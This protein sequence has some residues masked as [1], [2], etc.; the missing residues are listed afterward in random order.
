MWVNVWEKESVK[1]NCLNF[2][3]M[4]MNDLIN[5]PEVTI[6]FQETNRTEFKATNTIIQSYRNDKKQS[7][8]VITLEGIKA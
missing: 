3:R 6:I 8:K 5:T 2:G 1:S 7:E 4:Q